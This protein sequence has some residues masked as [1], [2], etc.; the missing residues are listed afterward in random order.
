MKMESEIWRLN[1]VSAA[2]RLPLA[3]PAFLKIM[4]ERQLRQNEQTALGSV[5]AVHAAEE[6]YQSA[7]GGFAC[8]LSAL[9]SEA[10]KRASGQT[11]HLMTR[12]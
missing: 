8:A 1:E 11:T 5:R 6:S 3:D 4:E 12:N 10:R 7:Q 2:V 9:G